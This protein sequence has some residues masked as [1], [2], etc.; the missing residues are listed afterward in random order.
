[1]SHFGYILAVFQ[2]KR[3]VTQKH[4]KKVPTCSVVGETKALT[5]SVYLLKQQVPT[6]SAYS[7]YLQKAPTE[8]AYRKCLLAQTESADR[9]WL[10]KVPTES[11]YRKWLQK[12]PTESAYRKCL[13][14][15]PTCSVICCYCILVITERHVEITYFGLV[16]IALIIR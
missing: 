14:K 8:I 2:E 5:E 11:A 13:Q 6:A 3:N 16:G 1:M 9:K 15:V 4:R 12:V 10:Q 7:K